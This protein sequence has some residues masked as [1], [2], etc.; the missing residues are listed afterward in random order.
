MVVS[1]PLCMAGQVLGLLQ[2]FAIPVYPH[3][4]FVLSQD[5]ASFSG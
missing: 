2:D 1:L 4:E 3:C 5:A